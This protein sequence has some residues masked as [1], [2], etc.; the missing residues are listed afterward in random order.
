MRISLL[1]LLLPIMVYCQHHSNHR[2]AKMVYTTAAM[3]RSSQ[4]MY[5]LNYFEAVFPNVYKECLSP[6]NKCKGEGELCSISWMKYTSAYSNQD[7]SYMLC[8]RGLSC[9]R[10]GYESEQGKSD[11]R[12]PEST[13]WGICIHQSKIPDAAREVTP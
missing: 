11:P 7:V 10:Y 3:E 2:Y 4:P 5:L 6:Y 9:I 12:N 13:E 8:G 1:L